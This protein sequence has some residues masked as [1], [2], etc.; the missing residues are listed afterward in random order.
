ML[1]R[2]DSLD[3]GEPFETFSRC[4]QITQFNNVAQMHR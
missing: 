2:D 1:E 4:V 3:V